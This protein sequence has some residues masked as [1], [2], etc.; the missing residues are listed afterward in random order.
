MMIVPTFVAPSSIEGVGLF[1]EEPI[2]RGTPIWVL[3][4]RF[5]LHFTQGELMALPRLQRA[6]V[7]R[8]GY[9]HM[10]RAGVTVVEYD[11]GRFMNH[12]E[13]ANTDFTDPEIGWAVKDIAA[14]EEITCNYADFEPGFAI[15]PG[16]R[17][18]AAG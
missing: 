3:N 17:F 4:E 14:G 7:E 6:F 8:Y 13:D 15:Q 9:A 11:N 5:D 16:R 18:V 1:A 12:A 2:A 10:R